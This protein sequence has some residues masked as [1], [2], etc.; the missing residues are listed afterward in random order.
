MLVLWELLK[1]ILGNVENHM[2]C[3]GKAINSKRLQDNY[4]ISNNIQHLQES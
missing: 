1:H 3:W 4:V 2:A